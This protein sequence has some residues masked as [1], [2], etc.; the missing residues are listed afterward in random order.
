MIANTFLMDIF[1]EICA[2]MIIADYT[3]GIRISWAFNEFN[4]LHA[5]LQFC[6]FMQ[7]FSAVFV[8]AI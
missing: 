6:T 1:Y 4:E 3:N 8:V 5:V 7:S 2:E